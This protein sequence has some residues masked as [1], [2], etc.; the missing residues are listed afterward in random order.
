MVLE[1]KVAVVSGGGRGIGRSIAIVLSRGGAAVVMTGRTTSEIHR[2]V[3]AEVVAFGRTG[4]AVHV[5]LSQRETIQPG[6]EEIFSH[7]PTINILANN[8]EIG[9]AKSQTDHRI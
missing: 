1:D 7:S 3:P 4:L 5:D 9:G 2:V 8:A 6:M